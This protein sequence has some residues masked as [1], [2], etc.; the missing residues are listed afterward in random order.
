VTRR[1]VAEAGLEDEIV[2]DS[3]GTGDWHIGHPPDERATTAARGRGIT[4]EGQARQV[5]ADDFRSHDLVVAMDR[6]NERDL[7]A[8]APDEESRR[9]VVLFRSFDPEAPGDLDVP[10]P[11][12]GGDDGFEH[13]LDVVDRAA[14]G[15]LEHL[16]SRS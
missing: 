9:K 6:A 13:V 3:A 2:V 10:D 8:L 4:L 11:Y 14:R 15:L 1:L 12:Y 16:R 7:L 5:A